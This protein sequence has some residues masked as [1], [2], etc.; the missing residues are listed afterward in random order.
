MGYRRLT[1]AFSRRTLLHL[2]ARL[3]SGL[4]YM[5]QLKYSHSDVKADNVLLDLQNG[6]LQPIISDFGI[7]RL[8]DKSQ[9]SVQAF[10]V[11]T[12]KGASIAYASPESINWLR[13]RTRL[14]NGDLTWLL[15]SDVY[16]LAVLIFETVTRTRPYK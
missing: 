3:G 16:S 9:L 15:Q 7:S 8:V 4:A 5:H 12:I 1:V 14:V 11:S 13:G 10:N 6:Q 2:L